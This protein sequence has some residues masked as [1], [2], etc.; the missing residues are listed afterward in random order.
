MS[1]VQNKMDLKMSLQ[2]LN[3]HRFSMKAGGNFSQTLNELKSDPD[4]EYAEPN[5][6]LRIAT[7]EYAAGINSESYSV[8]DIQTMVPQAGTQF[9]QNFAG[10]GVDAAWTTSKTLAQNSDRPIIAIIDSGVDYNHDIFQN[11]GA[12]WVNS[13]ETPGNGVDDD[14]NGYIDD[15]YGYNFRDRNG[16]PMDNNNHGTHVAGIALGA[17]RDIFGASSTAK[18][19][20]MAL[21]FLGSDGSGSTSDAISA[22]YYAVRNGAQIIN[23]SWGGGSYSQ[24]LHDAMTYAYNN[25]VFI[26]SAAGNYSKNNDSVNFYPANYPVP[27]QVAVASSTDSDNLS[28]F[29]NYGITTVQ[30][31]APGSF[32]LSSI[33]NNQYNYMSG[34]SMAAPFVA[35]VAGLILREAPN[36][37]GYQIRN[38]ILNTV[39]TSGSLSSKVSSGGRV[40]AYDS[41]TASQGEVGSAAYQ[42]SYKAEVRSPASVSSASAETAAKGCGTV[43]SIMA[44][45]IGGGSGTGSSPG[46]LV[47]ILGMTLVPLIIWQVLRRRSESMGINRRRFE[48]FKMDSEIKV[49]VGGKELIGQMNTISEGGLSFSAEELLSKGGIVNIQIQSPDGKDVVQVQG[50]IVWCEKNQAYG[51]QFDEAKDSAR[52]LIRSWTQN[53]VKLGQH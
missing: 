41:V 18:V 20:I 11:S 16:N 28:G 14:G 50:H 32:I 42:P 13:A 47:F 19:R 6:I 23:N 7:D 21:K 17:T 35:G 36:L 39:T 5:Y 26:V 30:V 24:S 53:L 3:V 46:F 31:A 12:M 1:K 4:V 29:S 15:I 8:G 45:G 44:R 43:S 40:D 34:T 52:S 48:R 22:I 27:G 9:V 37:T 2:G 51:V 10:V 38:I 33:R 25:Q 49:N